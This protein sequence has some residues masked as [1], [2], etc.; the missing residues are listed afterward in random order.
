MIE[1]GWWKKTPTT[2]EKR[3]LWQLSDAFGGGGLKLLNA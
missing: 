1:C 2:G 3:R